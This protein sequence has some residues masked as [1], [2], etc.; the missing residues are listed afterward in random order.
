MGEKCR[1]KER[2][3]MNDTIYKE[4]EEFKYL[5]LKKRGFGIF[6]NNFLVGRV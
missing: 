1:R 2:R 3:E 5:E 4:A 6:P